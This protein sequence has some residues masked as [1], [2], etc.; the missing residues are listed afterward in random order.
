M[1]ELDS[2]TAAAADF[3]DQHYAGAEPVFLEPGRKL[4]LGSPARPRSC[5]FCGLS[6]PQVTF[7]DEAHALPAAF[8]NTGLFSHYECDTCNHLFGEGIEDHLGRWSKPMR[9][10]S[11]IK[12]RKGVST[13]KK[14]GPDKGWRVEYADGGFRLSEYEA[15]PVL[16]VDE[17]AKLLRFELHRD[18]YVP[19][20]AL[21]GLVKIGLTLLPEVELPNFVETFEW[22]R[23]PD[24]SQNF[25]AEF[26][27]IRTV[28]PGPMRNDLIVLMLMRRRTGVDDVPYAFYTMAYGNEV[29]QV[30]IPSIKQDA[31][32]NGKKLS[33]VPFPNPG[34]RDPSIYGRPRTKIENLTGRHP[35]RGEKVPVSFG[36]DRVEIRDVSTANNRAGTEQL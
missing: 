13:I 15:D 36:F 5:R 14:P 35:V 22:I 27:I 25:V 9:T 6:E 2:A 24:H 17:E 21:K 29:L 16:T 7:R 18:T 1:D 28:I 10:L 3:Y 23:N 33:F 32:I 4:M 26:P 31:C 19:V 20:A 30:F 11:R 12:G 8:G 34:S